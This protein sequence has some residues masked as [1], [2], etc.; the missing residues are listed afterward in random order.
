[1]ALSQDLMFLR[2][3]LAAQLKT[4]KTNCDKVPAEILKTK[5]QKGYDAL[6]S[7]IKEKASEYATRATLRDIRIHMDFLKE[8]IAIIESIIASSD[9]VKELSYAVFARKDMEEVNQL[10]ENLREQIVKALMPYTDG[11]TVL[12][13]EIQKTV[14]K[15]QENENKAVLII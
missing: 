11:K 6:R 2:D 3:E 12:I 14:E 8:G 10:V 1:M 5:Y 7:D 4:L 13:G 15:I 9:D